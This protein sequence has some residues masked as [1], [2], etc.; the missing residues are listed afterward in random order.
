MGV[1]EDP[2]SDE[3]DGDARQEPEEAAPSVQQ[4]DSQLQAASKPL[5]GK[6]TRTDRNRDKRRKQAETALKAKASLKKQRRDLQSLKQLQHAI[7]EQEAEKQAL[8]AR[9]AADK[10]EAAKTKPPR[11]GRHKFEPQPMQVRT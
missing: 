1:Q 3:E 11:L 9:K 8:A 6:K 4:T 10:A 7:V 2:V 5:P